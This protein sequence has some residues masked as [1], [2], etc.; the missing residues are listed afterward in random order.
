MF[1]DALGYAA[2][3]ITAICFLPQIHQTLKSR[4]ASD[5]SLWMLLLTLLSVLLYEIYAALLGLWPVVI[6][7]GVFFLLVMFELILK[8]RFSASPSTEQDSTATR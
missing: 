7:N 8:I 3:G 4:S 1:V 2:G 5:V 6:M